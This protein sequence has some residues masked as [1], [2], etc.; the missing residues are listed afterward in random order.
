MTNRGVLLERF[1]ANYPTSA[2]LANEPELRERMKIMLGVIAELR[3]QAVEA[4]SVAQLQEVHTLET[5]MSRMFMNMQ[6]RQRDAVQ[7]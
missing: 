2:M 3:T 6:T 1:F 7:V 4:R 5:D